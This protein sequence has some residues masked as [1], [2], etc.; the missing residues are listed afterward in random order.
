MSPAYLLKAHPA[1]VQALQQENEGKLQVVLALVIAER[2]TSADPDPRSFASA[3]AWQQDLRDRQQA[4]V[5]REIGPTL[6]QLRELGLRLFNAGTL[7]VLIVEGTVAVLRRAL[8]LPGV[9]FAAFPAR[10]ERIGTVP[11]PLVTT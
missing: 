2:D 8:E 6:A 10:I 11:A 3:A 7:G 1:L 9:E 4:H 5:E